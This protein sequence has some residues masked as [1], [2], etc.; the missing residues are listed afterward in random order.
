LKEKACHSSIVVAAEGA[1][2]VG[3]EMAGRKTFRLCPEIADSTALRRIK[4][5]RDGCQVMYGH[6]QC[7]GPPYAFDRIPATRYAKAVELAAEGSSA[8]WSHKPPL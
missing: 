5:H 2:P 3:G 8:I 7:G 4:K 6:V 1:K